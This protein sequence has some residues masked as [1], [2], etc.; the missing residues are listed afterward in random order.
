MQTEHLCALSDGFY[1]FPR[2]GEGL[3]HM[4]AATW[5]SQPTGNL[6]SLRSLSTA[7]AFGFS[8]LVPSAERSTK[9]LFLL[10]RGSKVK[11]MSHKTNLVPRSVFHE[12][13]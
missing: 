4:G 3:A 1:L 5:T 13:S 12:P 8:S 7:A 10:P 2:Q 6:V 9:I 11:S